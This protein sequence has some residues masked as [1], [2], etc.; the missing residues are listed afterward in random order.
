MEGRKKIDADLK[1]RLRKGSQQAKRA[2]IPVAKKINTKYVNYLRNAYVGYKVTP[3]KNV[4][5][6]PRSVS[7]AVSRV[8]TLPILYL[9][10]SRREYSFPR[11][12][13]EQV[14]GT[15]TWGVSGE[16]EIIGGNV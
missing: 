5:I 12:L 7:L 11:R 6:M 14:F 1:R 13:D 9:L 10:P 4:S 3:I 8:T 15:S 16:E 2:S